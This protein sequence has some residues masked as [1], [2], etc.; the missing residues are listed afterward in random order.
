MISTLSTV[1]SYSAFLFLFYSPSPFVSFSFHTF[2]YFFLLFLTFPLF[3]LFP[4]FFLLLLPVFSLLLSFSSVP[5]LA[6]TND[7][8]L[9]FLFSRIFNYFKIC[10]LLSLLL[11]QLQHLCAFFP[12]FFLVRIAI[13]L[14][15]LLF[16]EFFVSF[17][18][19]IAYHA[20]WLITGRDDS[21]KPDRRR[22]NF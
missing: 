18:I 1:S 2:V 8:S 3:F 4:Y 17:F 15:L 22:W 9:F 21:G 6:I 16:L 19:I 11:L 14:L 7:S 20:S 12:S 13:F 5:F 10:V